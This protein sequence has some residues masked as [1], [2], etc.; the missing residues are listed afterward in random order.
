MKKMDRSIIFIWTI[1]ILIILMLLI[2]MRNTDYVCKNIYL[3]S[4]ITIMILNIIILLTIRGGD[5][6][7]TPERR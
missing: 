1:L 5:C 4:N 2:F 6:P 3:Q 7:K